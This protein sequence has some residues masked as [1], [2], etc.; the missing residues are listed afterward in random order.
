MRH[1]STLLLERTFFVLLA[2]FYTVTASASQ[3]VDLFKTR[4]VLTQDGQRYEYSR[5][6][7]ASGQS[8]IY[9][10]NENF[11]LRTFKSP[12]PIR[13]TQRFLEGYATLTDHGIK[14]IVGVEKSGEGWVI[15]PYVNVVMT[16][17]YFLFYM[18]KINSKNPAQFQKMVQGFLDFAVQTKEFEDMG[19]FH[20]GQLVWNGTRWLLLDWNHENELAMP[21]SRITFVHGLETPSLLAKTLLDQADAAIIAARRV[22]S[23]RLFTPQFDIPQNATSY[24]F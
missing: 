10:I 22:S 16:L 18:Q 20:S 24:P 11:V 3:C 1:L 7:S 12:N 8:I 23:P 2:S 13:S 4:E 6:I 21:T 9:R 17:E 5:I 15:Q 14:D 19:D